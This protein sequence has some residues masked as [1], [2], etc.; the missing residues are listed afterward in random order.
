MEID[1]W[2]KF[3]NGNIPICPYCSK[4]NFSIFSPLKWS[5]TVEMVHLRGLKKLKNGSKNSFFLYFWPTI[6]FSFGLSYFRSDTAG[7]ERI[8]WET[9]KLGPFFGQNRLFW[10]KLEWHLLCIVIFFAIQKRIFFDWAS[11]NGNESFMKWKCFNV[12]KLTF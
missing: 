1:F 11:L 9:K 12:Q 6:A 3:T 10:L 2:P 8:D 7:M 5:F 4:S